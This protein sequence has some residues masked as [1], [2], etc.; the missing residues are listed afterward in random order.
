MTA[1]CLLS[2]K[3]LTNVPQK[4]RGEEQR[5]LTPKKTDDVTWCHHEYWHQQM[6]IN[7]DDIVFTREQNTMTKARHF[8]F[9]GM[10]TLGDIFPFLSLA[11]EMQLRGH[12]VTI[13]LAPVHAS[14]AEKAGISYKIFGTQADYDAALRHPDM[15][16]IRKGMG[17]VLE[18]SKSVLTELPGYIA[19]L[20]AEQDCVLVVHPLGLP[21]ADIARSFRPDIPVVA[22]YLAPSN[23]RTVHNPLVMGDLFIPQWLPVWMRRWLWTYADKNFIDPVAVPIINQARQA[24]NLSTISSLA[25]HMYA[26]PDL[27][28]SFFP[29]WFAPVQ[30]DWPAPLAMGEFQLYDSNLVTDLSTELE[31]F[32]AAGPAPLIFTPGSGNIQ[33]SHYFL[34]AQQAVQKL[35]L[36]AIFLTSHREQITTALPDNILWQSYLPLRS[37][38]P[39][40]SALIHHGGIGTTAEALRAGTPQLVT[41]LAFDQF[42]NAARVKKLGTGDFIRMSRLTGSKLTRSLQQL[43]AS[44][45]IKTSC[46]QVAKKFKQNGYADSLC[47]AIETLQSKQKS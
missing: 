5:D 34:C 35:G 2:L 13:L 15:W 8:I 17:I 27:S 10:G 16:E 33:A 41:P 21:A 38:L 45:V 46:A 32:L 43:L 28:I 30:P 25:P 3:I 1:K 6:W 40:A 29:D 44:E 7:F 4:N 42:D 14:H 22:A 47:N 36:R 20:S 26:V 39:R 24:R 23:L 37:I 11:V 9:L 18:S 19:S 31:E 12:E